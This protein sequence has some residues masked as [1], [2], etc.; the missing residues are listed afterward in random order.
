MEQQ[1]LTIDQAMLYMKA[2]YNKAYSRSYL[3]RL[4]C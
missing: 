3:A 1:S 2:R 4:R